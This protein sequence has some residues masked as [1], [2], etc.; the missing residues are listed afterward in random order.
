MRYPTLLH[1][2]VAA[3]MAVVMIAGMPAASAAAP[4][5]RKATT[6]K[7]MRQT[8]RVAQLPVGTQRPTSE[9]LLSIGQGQL[10]TLPSGIASV[11]TS[12]PEVADVYVNNPRQ[13]NIFAK[14]AGEATIFA[15]SASGA[16]LYATN[17]RAV[18]NVTSMDRMLKLA[19][20]DADIKVTTAGQLAVLTGTVATPDDAAQAELLV[21]TMLN[22]GIDVVAPNAQLKVAVISRLR[23]ATP[24][25]VMLQVKIAEVN[26]SL[27]KEIASNLTTRDR[28]SGINVGV[29]QGRDFGS[30]GSVDVSSFPKLDASSIY[31]LP[32]GS[33]SLP[34][35]PATGQFITQAGAAVGFKGLGAG[36]TTLGLLG[37]L[38]GVDVAAA[39][40]LS[41]K[42]GLVSTL[43]EPNL[44]ALSGETASF[45]AGGEFPIPISQSLG[46]IS[47]EYKQYGVS[48][49]FTPTVLADG[50]I[51]MRVRP[52]VSQLSSEGAVTL[53]GFNIPAFITR[54][55]ETTVELG[56]GQSFMIGGL[57]QNSNVNSIDKVPG[58]GDVPVLGAMFRSNGYRRNQTELMI[59]VT[60]YLVKPV[61]ANEIKLP[62]DGLKTPTDL[63]NFLMG[64][65]FSG[66]KGAKR[67]TPTLAPSVTVPARPSVGQVTTPAPLQ[68]SAA[69]KATPSVAPGFS[70]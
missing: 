48:L 21:K 28:G 54:R 66:T 49:A 33:I 24:L 42:N 38:F 39:F 53:N 61:S 10:V 7:S 58:L 51:S 20:P 9:V 65:D 17:V 12:N 22:P 43:A 40:D 64:Q 27:S 57:I 36:K 1:R 31:G 8:A 30:I 15:T 23:T 14:T 18:P 13:V 32:A 62:T 70:N 50:R 67:A 34:F 41:E 59:I 56:S 29:I 2:S 16:V 68:R 19:M 52:E 26:R 55:S 11:W 3:T 45:L 4:K 37:N 46:T 47:I 35:N 5:A 44:T 25:Q 69:R 6:G 63:Q 60:P